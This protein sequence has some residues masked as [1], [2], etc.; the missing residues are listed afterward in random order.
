[1]NDFVTTYITTVQ[2]ALG[3]MNP[4]DFEAVADI[5]YAAYRDGHTVYT[6]GNGACAALASHMACDLGKG[7]AGDLGQGAA[8]S[9]DRRVR[10]VSLVD[11]ASLLTALANDIR[12][13]DVFVEQLKNV[14]EPGDV[15][16]GL[17]G[18]GGSPNVLVA[19]EYAQACGAITVGFTGAQ[20]QADNLRRL[21]QF[22]ISA[23]LT[24]MEQIEDLHVIFHHIVSLI[25]REK[26]AAQRR[27]GR[28]A[29]VPRAGTSTMHKAAI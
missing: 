20:A 26:I 29:D 24:L 16:I 25:V 28:S 12:Y 3:R 19:M 13:E 7:T 4:T 21:C 14:L 22:H 23:P 5:I 2:Q 15:V 27:A 1:M 18:S 11:N 9:G 8:R 17:S 10:I 6:L